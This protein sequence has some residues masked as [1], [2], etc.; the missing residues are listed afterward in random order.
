MLSEKPWKLERMALFFA[1][2]FIGLSCIVSIGTAATFLHG[3]KQFESNT[4]FAV[5]LA[6][7]TIHG[8][9]LLGT[10]AVMLWFQIKWSDAFGFSTP[11][12]AR[13]MIAG[14]LIGVILVP[15]GQVLLFVSSLGIER[16][17][18]KPTPQ[19][20][21]QTLQEAQSW[22]AEAYLIVWSIIIAPVAEEMLFR[23]VLYAGVKQMGF[24]RIALWGTALLFA[25]IHFSAAIF[26]PLTVFGLALAWL[27]DRTDNLL[28]PI[29]AHATF[30]AI[31]LLIMYFWEPFQKSVEHWFG[32]H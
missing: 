8:P 12:C 27:Y 3:G 16:L 18:G 23:G 26:V 21:I 1:V 24:P 25:T 29:S 17:G 6:T 20:A 15:V 5:L 30:N 10:T 32:P 9:I 7:L 22:P 2:F 4:V 14:I 11:P 28:A 31:N 19:Q 13:V